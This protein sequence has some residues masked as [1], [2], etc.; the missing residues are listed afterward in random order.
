MRHR[1]HSVSLRAAGPGSF[2]EKWS[3]ASCVFRTSSA[4]KPYEER[5]PVNIDVKRQVARAMSIELRGDTAELLVWTQAGSRRG[6]ALST[7]F[8]LASLG[9][10]I[11]AGCWLCWSS[12]LGRGGTNSPPG[13]SPRPH[14][15]KQWRGGGRG[16]L[17]CHTPVRQWARAVPANARVSCLRR[18]PGLPCHATRQEV[19][20]CWALLSWR[21]QRTES[22]G[23]RDRSVGRRQAGEGP[24]PGDTDGQVAPGHPACLVI[25]LRPWSQPRLLPTPGPPSSSTSVG[26][27]PQVL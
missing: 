24:G 9:H 19:V 3:G 25:R 10:V 21:A 13:L 17:S 27:R 22:S 12:C 23:R 6:K 18:E 7:C 20:T 14:R 16:R 5:G 8:C 15:T 4:S 11:G 2:A 1:P 26:G